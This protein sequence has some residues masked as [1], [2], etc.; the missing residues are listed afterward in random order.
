MFTEKDLEQLKEKGIS[1]D[2]AKD[3]VRNFEKGFP[4]IKLAAPATPGD[5]IIQIDKDQLK[6]YVQFYEENSPALDIVKFV[7]ASGAAT[8]MFKDLFTWRDELRKGNSSENI[9][10]S[11]QQAAQFFAEINPLLSGMIFRM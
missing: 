3:Q 8:R 4:F 10:A 1:V 5:G 7:P 2:M 11:D 9:S 6:E